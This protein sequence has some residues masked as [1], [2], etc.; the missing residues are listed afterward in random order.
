[1]H[2]PIWVCAIRLKLEDDDPVEEEIESVGLPILVS[3]DSHD[4]SDVGSRRTEFEMA[5]ADFAELSLALKGT[6]GRRCV[7]A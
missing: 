5:E 1:M 2:P 3:S 7:H 4:L 6:G